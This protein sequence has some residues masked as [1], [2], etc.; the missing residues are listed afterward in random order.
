MDRLCVPLLLAILALVLGCSGDRPSATDGRDDAAHDAATAAAIAAAEAKAR[1]AEGKATKADVAAA[2]ARADALA[3]AA[4]AEDAR[5]A[6]LRAE[7]EARAQRERAEAI[8]E[9][10]ARLGWWATAGGMALLVLAAGASALGWWYGLGRLSQ[11]IGLAMGASGGAALVMGLSW[12][13][14]PILA[15]VIILGG[16]LV[17]LLRRA[18]RAISDH[19]ERMHAVDPL[20]GG[21]E[22][23][24]IS[25]TEQAKAGIW[26]AVQRLRGKDADQDKLRRLIGNPN[27]GA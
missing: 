6:K 8:A 16:A 9:D 4:E 26:M 7:D 18:S 23:K 15:A 11:G 22:A 27:P 14:L 13:W 25:A 12:G 5:Q 1:M 2:Q 20:T 10:R 19:A 17:L 21:V 3:T 24:V